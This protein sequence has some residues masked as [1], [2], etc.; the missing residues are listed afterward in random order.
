MSKTSDSKNKYRGFRE[1][2]DDGE[3]R[4]NKK[5]INETHKDKVKFREKMKKIDPKT[6]SEEDFDDDYCN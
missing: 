5:R 4:P 2:Y 6:F 3:A 1:F